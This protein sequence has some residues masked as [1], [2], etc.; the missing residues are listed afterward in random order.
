MTNPKI[1]PLI[2]AKGGNK[3]LENKNLIEINGKESVLYSV[4]AAKQSKW[5]S[6]VC[7]STEDQRIASTCESYGSHVINRPI[8]LSQPLT[9]H[10]DV[11]VHAYDEILKVMGKVDIVVVLL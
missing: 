4:D 9:N 3:S 7:V 11:I 5:V 8:H 2:T 6:H 1:V 10:G